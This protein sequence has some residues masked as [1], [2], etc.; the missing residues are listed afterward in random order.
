MVEERIGEVAHYWPRAHAAE[1]RVEDAVVR[2]GDRLRIRG[3]GHDF[4][5]TV[6]SIEVDHRPRNVGHPDEHF[7]IHVENP[8]HERDEVLLVRDTGGPKE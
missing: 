4:V 5:Q 2:V 1:L 7:A 6:T 8:V 3:H